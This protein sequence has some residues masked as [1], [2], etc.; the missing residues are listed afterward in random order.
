LLLITLLLLLLLPLLFLLGTPS[1]QLQMLLLAHAFRK[2]T[3]LLLQ[4]VLLAGKCNSLV[5]LLGAKPAQA[6]T[7][8]HGSPY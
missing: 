8:R 5:Q 2:N 6:C 7:H 4:V 1:W 3:L